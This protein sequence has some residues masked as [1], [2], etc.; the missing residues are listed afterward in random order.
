MRVK[1]ELVYTAIIRDISERKAQ[2]RQLQ[3]QATHDP[4]TALPNRPAFAA[5]LD[6]LLAGTPGK[7]QV[8]LMMIDLDRFKEVNDTLGHNVGDYVLHEVARRLEE[9]ARNHGFI[10]RIGGDEFAL[11]VAGSDRAHRPRLSA[12]SR[13]L[14]DSLKK[15]I[16][17]CGVAIDVGLSIGIALFP[18]HAK[19]A[20]TLFKNADVAMY[21]AKRAASGFEYY[22]PGNDSHSVR[23]LTIATRL[24]QAIAERR[25]ELHYQ[26][27]VHLGTARVDG[28]EALVRW[29]DEMLGAVGPQEFIALAESTDLIQ[30]LSEWTLEEALRQSAAWRA[31]GIDLRIAINVSARLL[32]DKSFPS[33]LGFMLTDAGV[34]P[35]RI[36][37]EITESAMMHDPKRAMQVIDGLAGLGVRISIDDYGTGYSS[38]AYLRDLPVHALKLDRSF[39]AG[40][41]RNEGDKIIVASTVQMAHAMKL[42]IVAE[43]VETAADAAVLR[44]LGYDHAQGYW[45]SAALPPDRFGPWL[46]RFNSASVYDLR[47]DKVRTGS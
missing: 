28:A 45:Y 6:S 30:P 8:A 5:H 36:E 41:R 13:R 46:E 3:F 19:D 15:P 2:Q 37:L 7:G 26:P 47:R 9:T 1:D 32:Q 11:V 24:R 10:A 31:T 20:E 27:K 17:T 43:G 40:M 18:D 39:I 38:L 33:R 25:L 21:I 4:L 29:H 22:D 12:L 44:D 23:K 42:E 34:A 14:V 35:D 16:E